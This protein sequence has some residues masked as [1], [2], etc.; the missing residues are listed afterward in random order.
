MRTQYNP[1][2]AHGVV[3]FEAWF[4]AVSGPLSKSSVLPPV[5]VLIVSNVGFSLPPRT[6]PAAAAAAAAAAATPV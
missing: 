4:F 3:C 6:R 5:R 1:P 2:V